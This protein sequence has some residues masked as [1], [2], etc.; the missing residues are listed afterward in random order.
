MLKCHP[1][2][3][4]VLLLQNLNLQSLPLLRFLRAAC[5]R[6]FLTALQLERHDRFLN[7]KTDGKRFRFELSKVDWDSI[8]DLDT[9]AIQR[10]REDAAPWMSPCET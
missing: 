10:Q 6:R 9:S 8:S 7:A 1:V 5:S 3:R 2:V 4:K